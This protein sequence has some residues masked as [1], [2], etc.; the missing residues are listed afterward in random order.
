MQLVNKRAYLAIY[1]TYFD[2]KEKT[3]RTKLQY[4]KQFIAQSH[5]FVFFCKKTKKNVGMG[6]Y[7]NSK[8]HIVALSI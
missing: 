5:R 2:R 6:I 1:S 4:V 8:P 3:N 7:N